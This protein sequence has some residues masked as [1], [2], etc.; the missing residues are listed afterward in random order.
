MSNNEIDEFVNNLL[1]GKKSKTNLLDQLFTLPKKDT[2]GDMPHF[3]HI[4]PN[5]WQMCDTLYLPNDGGNQYC[6]V[7]ADVG[8]RLVDAQPMSQRSAKDIT[9]AI[10]AIYRRGI[11]KKPKLM[12]TDSGTEMRGQFDQYLEQIGVHHTTTKVGRSRSLSIVERKNMTIGKIIHKIILRT[13]L[14]STSSNKNASSKWV[15]YL[16]NIIK[17]INQKVHEQKVPQPSEHPTFNSKHPI[18][19]L[20]VGDK[21]RVQLDHPTDIHGER[22]HGVFRASDIKWNPQIRTIRS[23]LVKPDEPIMYLLDGDYGENKIECVGYTRN[24][25]LTVKANEQVET[26]TVT[27]AVEENRYEFEK[28]LE[29]KKVGKTY[30][31]LIKWKH[32]PKKDATWET[33]AELLKDVPQA[34]KNYDKKNPM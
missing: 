19:L 23:V 16:P 8:S 4:T 21:V 9:T 11:L 34:I 5:M 18:D 24:Q 32:Y 20:D 26:T 3:P 33:R 17:L 22:R 30:K 7:L 14:A 29:R 13:E 15:S 2:K 12:T 6:L 27:N 1:S 10:K 31:Y 25:L 28:I